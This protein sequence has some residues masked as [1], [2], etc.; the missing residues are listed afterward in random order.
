MSKKNL[1]FIISF[2][3]ID[4]NSD[5][6]FSLK[7]ALCALGLELSRH[8]KR[9]LLNWIS[10]ALRELSEEQYQYIIN[11]NSSGYKSI[12]E[13]LMNGLGANEHTVD[14]VNFLRWGNDLVKKDVLTAESILNEFYPFSEVRKF[15]DK[16]TAKV[17]YAH[18][19]ILSEFWML[20]SC[21]EERKNYALAALPL[22][23]KLCTFK[24]WAQNRANFYLATVFSILGDF[25][26]AIEHFIDTIV[27]KN[28]IPNQRRLI[29]QVIF[30]DYSIPPRLE[31][32][33]LSDNCIV[34]PSFWQCVSDGIS[35]VEI[36]S[37]LSHFSSRLLERC[38]PACDNYK[39]SYDD[40]SELNLFLTL[41]TSELKLYSQQEI[42]K[43]HILACNEKNPNQIRINANLNLAYYSYIQRHSAVN[44]IY[45]FS[46]SLFFG[47]S[48]AI[49]IA[50]QKV[51]IDADEQVVLLVLK[52]THL[53]NCSKAVNILQVARKIPVW[54]TGDISEELSFIERLIV[55]SE[56][57]N[58]QL[59]NK[60]ARVRA[61][62]L[63]IRGESVLDGGL[64]IQ[65]FEKGRKYLENSVLCDE[66]FV[67]DNIKNFSIYKNQH[68]IITHSLN[69]DY[70]YLEEVNSDKLVIVFSC[71]Y[72]YSSFTS[73]PSFNKNKKT[74]VL[75]INNPL[76]N[77]Y[78]D[79]EEVRVN[80]LI[81]N[82][83]LSKFS[84]DNILCYSGS[85][86][87]YAA[88][89]FASRYNLPSI[90]VTPQFNLNLWALARPN[91]A[92]RIYSINKMINLDK[93][94]YSDTS[95]FRTCV[96]IGRQPF[97]LLAFQAWFNHVITYN[98]F[99]IVVIKHDIAEHAGLIVR[100]YG[101]K[102][103]DVIYD[104]FRLINDLYTGKYNMHEVSLNDVRHIQRS[105]SDAK[106]GQ[107]VIKS[108]NGKYLTI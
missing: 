82:V 26:R 101:D 93:V 96:I 56:S 67:C 79:D 70:I 72:F 78:S 64:R 17:L 19:N 35:D 74:N 38:F 1:P 108:I 87:G 47:G 33:F 92:D 66:A 80:Y 91:D 3:D 30:N 24:T 77:W 68:N 20:S 105:I 25:S 104:K 22:L 16:Q 53:C 21:D 18:V 65:N 60:L 44:A 97:D 39:L 13:W 14:L 15:V 27:D 61:A 69:G 37:K 34:N 7:K 42:Q 41:A 71:R 99:T 5:E 106:D 6:L 4:D 94:S 51:L 84:R 50:I 62:F 48:D 40:I 49:K 36:K 29:F 28:S 86:G 12:C 57:M 95:G 55:L 2:M 102:F 63:C 11:W 83:A 81:E 54:V 52:D 73:V 46:M 88:L 43:V 89:K 100:A 23:M 85:M 98:D 45:Y 76:C 8:E 58:S 103:V 75:F 107:W 59:I 31:S 32:I 90:A 9:E 10:Y